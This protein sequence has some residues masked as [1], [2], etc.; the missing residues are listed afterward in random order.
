MNCGFIF[1]LKRV[2]WEYFFEVDL[3]FGV[4]SLFNNMILRIVV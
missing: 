2:V 3:F 4:L 1:K